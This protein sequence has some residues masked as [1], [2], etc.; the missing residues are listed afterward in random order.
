MLKCTTRRAVILSNQAVCYAGK[1]QLSVE[2]NSR[3]CLL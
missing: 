3:L 1:L 2:V